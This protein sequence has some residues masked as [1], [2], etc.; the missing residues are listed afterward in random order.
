MTA[1]LAVG[2]TQSGF[3]V[4]EFEPFD[5]VPLNA[6][7]VTPVT[8]PATMPRANRVAPATSSLAR[9][10]TGPAPLRPPD[11]HQLEEAQ[12]QRGQDHRSEER[13]VGKEGETRRA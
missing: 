1:A 12:E 7:K 3:A 8:E 5:V 9:D 10:H 6:A 11:P 13:R 4:K 2:A